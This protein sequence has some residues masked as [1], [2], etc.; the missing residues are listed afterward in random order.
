MIQ[1]KTKM[2][3]KKTKMEIYHQMKQLKCKS[4]PRQKGDYILLK[5]RL[6]IIN[7]ILNFI[8]ASYF[9]SKMGLFSNSGKL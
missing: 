9:A 3:K 8:T 2:E 1:N 6:Q 7:N 4:L 5:K